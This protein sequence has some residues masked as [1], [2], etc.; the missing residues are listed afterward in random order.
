MFTFEKQKKKFRSW[1]RREMAKEAEAS[2]RTYTA[3]RQSLDLCEARLEAM[4]TR[5]AGRLRRLEVRIAELE[6]A[7]ARFGE[8][9][10]RPVHKTARQRAL[11][12]LRG[13]T[14]RAH[15]VG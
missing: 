11:R 2:M 3:A 4:D 12:D 14:P 8:P 13:E 7:L 6:A 5:M 15:I 10:H 9:T 1:A